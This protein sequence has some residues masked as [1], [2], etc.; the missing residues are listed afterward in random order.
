MCAERSILRDREG[1][2]KVLLL[3][4][5]DI[6]VRRVLP[7]LRSAGVEQLEVASTSATTVS[8][9]GASVPRQYDSYE[10]ALATSDAVLVYV[11]TVN[12]AHASCALRA[13]QRGFHVVVDK[14]A[15]LTA[16]DAHE[17]AA[18]AA[19]SGRCLAEATV[20]DYHPRMVRALQTFAEAGSRPTHI[21][22][23]FSFP[24]LPQANFRTR[25]ELG[26]G[27][28]Y[29]L[30]PYAISIGHRCFGAP[31][32]EIIGRVLTTNGEVD[33]GFSMLAIY[34]DG[35]SVVGSFSCTTGYINRVDIAGPG[36]VVSLDRIFS[37]PATATTTIALRQHDAV[38]T[39][40]I[41]PA[42]SFEL[43]FRDLIQAIADG[44]HARFTDRLLQDA[45]QLD[46]L[47]QSA[48]ADEL[49]WR[50]DILVR[51]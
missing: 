24:P 29:D 23:A 1:M 5:S 28:L 44:R 4:Y 10:S 37:P 38:T 45:E 46:R 8:W 18:L 22:A 25:A 3:G 48:R 21:L 13:L 41:P 17:A 42:D 7:A 15:F 31:A 35:R 20:Y 47:R 6:A 27:I 2:M 34:P 43:F 12:S 36:I 40:E 30:G 9:P 49:D 19:A 16:R 11:S 51:P 50:Q 32:Q 26:G 14:P 39:I 33:T